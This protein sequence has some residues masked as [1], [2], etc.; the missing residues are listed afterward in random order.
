MR[1]TFNIHWHTAYAFGSIIYF[2]V[3][4]LVIQLLFSNAFPDNKA[5]FS[6]YRILDMGTNAGAAQAVLLV[7][8]LL[9]TLF[10]I[11]FGRYVYYMAEKRLLVGRESF[12]IHRFTKIFFFFIFATF[13]TLIAPDRENYHYFGSLVLFTPPVITYLG[14]LK[15]FHLPHWL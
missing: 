9:G 12:R 5:M 11:I 13:Y 14:A 1:R 15:W 10:S 7:F 6:I 3:G 2:M 4:I 8:L